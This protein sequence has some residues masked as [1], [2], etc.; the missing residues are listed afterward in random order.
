MARQRVKLVYDLGYRVT[1]DG[2]LLNPLGVELKGS[3][4]IFRGK[5]YLRIGVSKR[6]GEGTRYALAHQLVA[7][8]KYGDEYLHSDAVVRHLN[9]DGLDN[10]WDNVAI[11]TQS[12]NFMDRPREVRVRHARRA[13]SFR[14]C[15]TA[16]QVAHVRRLREQGLTYKKIREIYPISMSALSYLLNGK[17]YSDGEES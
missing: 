12:Q 1:E 16:K 7:Y 6:A 13:A 10:R 3:V 4:K 11:G 17:T 15:L 14:R 5:K 8:Q 2:R 9:D